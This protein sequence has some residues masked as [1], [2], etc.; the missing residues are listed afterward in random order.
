M[1]VSCPSEELSACMAWGM[2][3]AGLVYRLEAAPTALHHRCQNAR[4]AGAGSASWKALAEG[5][6]TSLVS[7]DVTGC[8]TFG[9]L[10]GGR[11]SDA[12]DV[13]AWSAYLLPLMA[14]TQLEG[15]C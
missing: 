12:Q 4:P 1:R 10:L 9:T 5:S 7:L 11:Q 6:A 15:A 8:A 13:T 2:L 3:A 14:C